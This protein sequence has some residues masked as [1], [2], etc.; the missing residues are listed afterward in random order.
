M[1]LEFCETVNPNLDNFEADGV[2]TSN[3]LIQG[4]SID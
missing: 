1:T 3:Y 4:R 2:S